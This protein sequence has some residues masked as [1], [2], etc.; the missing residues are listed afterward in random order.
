[1]IILNPKVRCI[2]LSSDKERWDSI[3]SSFGSSIIRIPAI[4]GMF[5]S[6]GEFD[7]YTCPKWKEP[8]PMISM[9]YSF[10][11]PTTYGC[12]LSQ[13]KAWK[14]FLKTDEEWTI[15]IEDDVE[16]IKDI[17]KI[18]IPDDCDFYYLIGSNHPGKRLIVYEDGSPKFTRTLAAYLISRQA[19]ELAIKAMD[20]C[21]Y[22]Q[23]D[24]QVPLRIFNSMKDVNFKTPE[25]PEIGRINASTQKESIIQH[26][27]LAKIST[28]TKNGKKSWIPD[29]LL[30]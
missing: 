20:G 14:D 21:H 28:F 16:I 22:Y 12:N 11:F 18:E 4:D 3:V 30:P 5:F 13:V 24:L 29:F 23:T 6:S 17:K 19:A 2:N 8:T 1:M 15:I 10:L 7:R 9:E 25:W 27:K 26:N